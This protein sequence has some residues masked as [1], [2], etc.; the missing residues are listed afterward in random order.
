MSSAMRNCWWLIQ[1]HLRAWSAIVKNQCFLDPVSWSWETAGRGI[2]KNRAS[3]AKTEKWYPNLWIRRRDQSSFLAGEFLPEEGRV[4]GFT[5]RN[6]IFTRHIFMPS[7][8]ATVHLQ[9]G[10]KIPPICG[11][12]GNSR[13]VNSVM[14][15]AKKAPIPA[16]SND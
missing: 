10:L 11:F 1:C 7:L 15:N 14:P 16:L 5:L 9:K 12:R 13:F 3:C 2:K 8:A 4:H 6:V